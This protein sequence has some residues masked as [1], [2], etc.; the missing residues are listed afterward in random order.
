MTLG[1][2]YHNVRI[3]IN[4]PCLCRFD[5]RIPNESK[6]SKTFNRSA[7]A[8]CI[9]AAREMVALLPDE[10]N[11]VGLISISPWW[12]LLHHLVTAGVILMVEIS[13]RA[14]HNPQQAEGLLNDS[15]KVVRWLA[16]MANDSLA[17]ERSWAVL[18][19]LLIISA[20]KIGRNTADVERDINTEA[21]ASSTLRHP[22][23][24]M[25]NMP[26][27]MVHLGPSPPNMQQQQQ[28]QQSGMWAD[29]DT[30]F[31]FR[32]LISN[33]FSF[34]HTRFDDAMM[35]MGDQPHHAHAHHLD[36]SQQPPIESYAPDVSIMPSNDPNMA[37][38]QLPSA[39]NF[40][41]VPHHHHS[42]SGGPPPPPPPPPPQPHP[43]VDT[44]I[45][46]VHKRAA[47]RMS[48]GVTQIE[49]PN[50]AFNHP[51]GGAAG[52]MTSS[53]LDAAAAVQGQ[54]DAGAQ[55]PQSRKG[56]SSASAVPP[57]PPSLN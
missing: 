11:P 51:W 9:S 30:S 43:Q 18:M 56:S 25:P 5:Y 57:P 17:A 15:K 35:V 40:P 26:E 45:E 1:L 27:E 13:M 55:I 10:P 24:E 2:Q 34:T 46:R 49:L 42:M 38:S 33:S 3:L 4:R 54:L 22:H 7:A 39:N 28:Q 53:Q 6:R 41:A 50:P 23:H 21:L 14:E 16:S 31:L 36:A 19:K 44:E 12:C 37:Y 29:P 47:K 52:F 8:T 48:Q 20:P 32:N